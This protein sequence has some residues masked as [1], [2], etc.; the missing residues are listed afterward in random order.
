MSLAS[1]TS[2]AASMTTT[3]SA[4]DP[5]RAGGWIALAFHDARPDERARRLDRAVRH[6]G[7]GR[8]VRLRGVL[9]GSARDDVQADSLEPACP[10]GV[11]G[12]PTKDNRRQNRE[13]NAQGGEQ[14]AA[15]LPDATR[16]AG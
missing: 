11:S 2:C 15:H 3:S 16:Q 14:I 7:D 1:P 4:V 8:G 12:E 10:I 13:L 6:R 5:V 9:D